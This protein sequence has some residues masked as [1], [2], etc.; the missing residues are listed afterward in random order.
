MLLMEGRMSL[1]FDGST[2][3]LAPGDLAYYSP[4]TTIFQSNP[5]NSW[6]LYLNFNEHPIWAPLKKRGAYL[7]AYEDAALMYILMSRIATAYESSNPKAV[8]L[9]RSQASLL[10]ELLRHEVTLATHR[11][12]LHEAALQML[13]EQIRNS[14]EADWTI[15][16]MAD[17]VHVSGRTL[18]RIFLTEYGITPIDLVVRERM[19]RAY[20]TLAQTDMTLEEVAMT[21]GY[22]SVTSFSRLF[23]KHIG[24]PPGQCRELRYDAHDGPTSVRILRG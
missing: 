13:T 18:N 23:K 22:E 20:D 11:P 3:E 12:R 9:A 24:K 7:R 16:S 15:A 10:A 14:P 4:G 6:Y 5:G 17:T 21:V 19:A 2:R 1:E 8:G